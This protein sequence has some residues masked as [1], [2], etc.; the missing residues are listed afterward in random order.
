MMKKPII[1]SKED[2]KKQKRKRKILIFSIQ[3]FLLVSFIGLWELLAS[4]GVINSFLVSKPSAIW[5]L[6]MCNKILNIVL[7]LKYSCFPPSATSTVTS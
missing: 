6:F 7:P 2:F 3:I 4:T 1:Q 5:E